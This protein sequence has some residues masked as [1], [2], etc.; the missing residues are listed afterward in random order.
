M[1]PTTSAAEDRRPVLILV[2]G[3]TLNREMWGPVRRHLDGRWRVI[4][5]DLPAHG[6][7]RAEPFTLDGA[8]ATVVEAARSVAPAPVLL[9]GDSLGGF[10]ALASAAALPREQLKGLVL[11]GATANFSGSALWAL[12][13]QQLLS[14]LMLKLLGPDRVFRLVAKQ[15]VGM[16]L[17]PAEAAAMVDAGLNPGAFGQAV[18]ALQGQD[19]RA[20]L[21][22]VPQP[23][24]LV[25]GARDKL[26]V[27]QEASFLAVAQ[28][29]SSHRFEA[30]AHGVT[31]RRSAEFAGLVN[32]FAARVFGG[33]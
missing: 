23:V 31:L 2:H 1:P 20:R 10:T 14:V 22:A 19:F 26:F 3:A 32:G 15:L 24:L 30:C 17:Q 13:R 25:N 18:A 12:R 33:A 27:R 28:R 7:R 16:G 29:A 4:A 21:A 6:A 9:A 5:P 11:G 8:V